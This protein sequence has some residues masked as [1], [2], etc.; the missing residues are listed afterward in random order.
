MVTKAFGVVEA[1]EFKI[2]AIF[3]SLG[4]DLYVLFSHKT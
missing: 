1:E 2:V 4:F 3:V